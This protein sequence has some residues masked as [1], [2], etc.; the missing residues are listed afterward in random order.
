MRPS[1]SAYVG[2]MGFGPAGFQYLRML[3][4]AQTT[5]PEVHIRRFVSAAVGSPVSDVQALNLLE[6]AGKLLDYPLAVLDY[7][8]WEQLARGSSA[9]ED[10]YTYE[11]KINQRVFRTGLPESEAILIGQQLQAAGLHRESMRYQCEQRETDGSRY[12]EWK[13]PAPKPAKIQALKA[14]GLT[15]LSEL[16][17]S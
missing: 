5:K 11:L 1:D 3:F 9:S 12:P 15:L 8:I 17:R 16:Q 2:V 10:P 13:I 14:Q 6:T 4:G 7:A